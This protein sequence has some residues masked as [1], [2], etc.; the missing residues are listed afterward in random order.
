VESQSIMS[1]TVAWPEWI[2]ALG[3]NVAVSI[4]VGV[5]IALAVRGLSRHRFWLEVTISALTWRA[6]IATAVLAFSYVGLSLYYGPVGE[7]VWTAIVNSLIGDSSG[8]F[9]RLPFV[10]SVAQLSFLTT[11]F[12]MLMLRRHWMPRSLLNEG[13]SL[14]RSLAVLAVVIVISAQM[15]GTSGIGGELYMKLN[16]FN[17]KMAKNLWYQIVLYLVLMD[18][19]FGVVQIAIRIATRPKVDADSPVLM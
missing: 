4:G 8:Y 3:V 2:A 1:K 12:V 14:L 6:F 5:L 7:G 15:Y 18:I 9:A 11:A 13:A 17:F 19:V 16:E 10:S